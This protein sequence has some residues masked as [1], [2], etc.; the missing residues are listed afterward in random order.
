MTH[1]EHLRFDWAARTEAERPSLYPSCSQIVQDAHPESKQVP[2]VRRPNDRKF[3]AT[4]SK[5]KRNET[6][7]PLDNEDRRL[8]SS[9]S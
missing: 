8:F 1:R 3:L 2:H 7:D 5:A 4:V 6:L 9:A